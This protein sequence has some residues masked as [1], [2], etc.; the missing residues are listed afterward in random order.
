[1][2]PIRWRRG[3]DWDSALSA[4]PRSLGIAA[5]WA[6]AAARSPVLR[7]WLAAG[8]RRAARQLIVDHAVWWRAVLYTICGHLGGLA[9]RAARPAQR[10]EPATAA[11]ARREHAAP[12]AAALEEAA[13]EAA[14]ESSAL[15]AGRARNLDRYLRLAAESLGLGDAF[16]SRLLRPRTPL[17]LALTDPSTGDRL[18]PAATL[19]ALLEDVQKR[20]LAPGP[21]PPHVHRAVA[22][23]V[24]RIRAEALQE[25]TE[26]TGD[27]FSV[28]EVDAA[29]QAARPHRQT[30][31]CFARPSGPKTVA[32]GC[33]RGPS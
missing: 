7:G 32:G 23:E 26:E 6:G 13:A 29:V 4:L 2:L 5:C 17:Q 21:P 27:A 1:M 10:P 3:A 16:L 15:A 12:A 24:R 14:A 30:L 18:G 28:D 11:R 25:T 19:D 9:V 20:G 31:P 8:T 33:S 22:E